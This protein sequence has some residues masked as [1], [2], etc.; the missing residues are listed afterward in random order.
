MG[1]AVACAG[2]SGFVFGG[3]IAVL[4][5]FD[6]SLAMRSQLLKFLALRTALPP[7]FASLHQKAGLTFALGDFPTFA[8]ASL[9]QRRENHLRRKAPWLRWLKGRD[10]CLLLGVVG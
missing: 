7:D 5:F 9:R 3:V 1:L 10:W 8:F 4:L 6:L 2:D